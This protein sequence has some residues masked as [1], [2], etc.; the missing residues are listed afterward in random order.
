MFLYNAKFL[1]VILSV[2][3]SFPE[4]FL[5]QALAAV[6]FDGEPF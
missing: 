5:A 2:I 4:L 6:K 3:S 1:I